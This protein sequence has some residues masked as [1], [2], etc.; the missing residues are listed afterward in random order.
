MQPRVA[1]I[2]AAGGT[3]ARFTASLNGASGTSPYASSGLP[4][5]F[6]QLKGR[7]IFVWS[8][9]TL[10]ASPSVAYVV[11]VAPPDL[12]TE[13]QTHIKSLA[14]KFRGK[15]LHVV[16]GGST[17]Q[18]SVHMGLMALEEYKPEFVLIHDAARPFL[19]A[20][21]LNRF[22][23]ALITTGACTTALRASDTIQKVDSGK[24]VETLDRECLVMVQTPQGGRFEWLL[25]GHR[26]AE[27]EDKATTD[28]AAILALAGHEVGIVDGAAYNLKI[29]RAEDMILA[30]ALIAI[31]FG[32]RM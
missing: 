25:Q 28:D 4:K 22:L 26:L 3:G 18:Q 17:R 19:T 9:E 13:V 30:D 1:A 32:D 23:D 12:V 6:L 8:L 11:V 24:V 10:L 14:N 27:K 7:P 2:L 16:P 29:T 15:E 20:E 31:L 5:Q 21:L